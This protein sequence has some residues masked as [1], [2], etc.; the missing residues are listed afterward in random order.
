[1]Q[2]RDEDRPEDPALAPD[3]QA[4]FNIAR[5][6]ESLRGKSGLT[7]Y[8]PGIA[9]RGCVNAAAMQKGDP[10]RRKHVP[11]TRG[12]AA[13]WC[14][15]SSRQAHGQQTWH[16]RPTV[17]PGLWQLVRSCCNWH[18]LFPPA[19]LEGC[20][21]GAH[22]GWGAKSTGKSWQMPA[23]SRGG[24]AREGRMPECDKSGT[25]NRQPNLLK[26]PGAHWQGSARNTGNPQPADP[27][28]RNALCSRPLRFRHSLPAIV[29]GPFNC[30]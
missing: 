7:R 30:G 22:E 21:A 18:R 8:R 29:D 4:R 15:R 24:P 25:L 19:T 11:L 14:G 1:M 10:S 28:G 23:R 5:K 27:G 20:A 13:A 2:R 26:W 12:G 6:L 3:C 9:K 16:S 17:T